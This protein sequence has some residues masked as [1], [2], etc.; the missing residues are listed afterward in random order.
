MVILNF[1]TYPESTG[2]NALKLLDAVVKFSQTNPELASKV[3]CAPSIL[4]LVYVRKTYRTINIMSQFVDNKNPGSSTG[5]TTPENLLEQEINFSLYNHSEHRVWS[6]SI[7]EDIKAIQAKGIKLVVC[8]ENVE[9][10][11]KVLEAEPFGIAYE[12]KDLIGSGVSVTTRPD[13]VKEFIEVTKGKTMVFIGAGVSTGEDVVK[14]LELGAE[15]VLL[16]S[17]FVKADNHLAKIEELV[18]PFNS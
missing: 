9:E 2:S 16:A 6:D 14:S 11:K 15:G 3:T 5:W 10:A 1:K 7:V 13:A 12:P 8:C 17:A 4:D 18:K